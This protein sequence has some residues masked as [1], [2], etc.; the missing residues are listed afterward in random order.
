MFIYNDNGSITFSLFS[1][2]PELRCALS[3]RSLGDLGKSQRDGRRIE[4]LLAQYGIT[5]KDLVEMNQVHGGNIRSVSRKDRNKIMSETDSLITQFSRVYL[6]INFADC[7]PLFFYDPEIRI[8]AVAHSGWRG[9]AATIAQTV[10]KNMRQQGST[11]QNIHVAIGPHI[12]GCCYSVSAER[13]D[14]FN[15]LF[16][17]DTNIVLQNEDSVY[18][19]L[20]AANKKLLESAGVLPEHID[21][22]ISCTSCQNTRYYSYRKDSQSTFGQMLGF[23]GI[24][25]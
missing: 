15:K 6:S 19:D 21:A 2:F 23:I 14:I 12:G 8:S 11:V 9:T 3:S 17:H 13:G 22:P 24:L 7:V 1:Q 20:G 4:Q 10:L 5:S 18:L 25:T 16:R